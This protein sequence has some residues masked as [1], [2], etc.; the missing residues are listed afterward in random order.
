MGGHSGHSSEEH[1]GY[2]GKGVARY[3]YGYDV[4]GGYK[5][6]D[7]GHQESRNGDLTRGSYYTDLPDGR[8]IHVKYYV[9]GYSGFVA[10]VRYEGKAKYDSS[11]YHDDSHEAIN[12]Y[13]S[14]SGSD[15]R[16]FGGIVGSI[17]HEGSDEGSSSSSYTG[18]TGG[19]V[20]HDFSTS[21]SHEIPQVFSAA[22]PSGGFDYADAVHHEDSDEGAFRTPLTRGFNRGRGND[23]SD[24]GAFRTPP[25]GGFNRGRGNDD[26]DE[27]NFYTPPRGGF[28]RGRDNDDS[29]EGVTYNNL[30]F[31]NSGHDDSDERFPLTIPTAG[32]SFRG[33]GDG[34][35]SD[36]RFPLV[37]PN[38]GLG[39]RGSNQV[40][41]VGSGYRAPNNI[42]ST[43]AAPATGYGFGGSI[44]G[45][46]HDDSDEDVF[47][48]R[49]SV[50][51]SL[52]GY[53][54]DNSNEGL[55]FALSNINSLGHVNSNHL[56]GHHPQD[57]NEGF[58][59]SRSR[60][61]GLTG[62]SRTHL[63][64]RPNMPGY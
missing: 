50:G 21:D 43:Y 19:G 44:R 29:D 23:D 54:R 56:F 12:N 58:T 34:S 52:K 27:G 25:R 48:S 46:G 17:S 11:G 39:Y 30:N 22:G 60:G 51:N 49:N 63:G 18:Y 7:F 59:F 2:K 35:D 9:N 45:R 10:D 16:V 26:S 6:G 47:F 57:S 40:A 1:H 61:G 64:F 20:G 13:V 38:V 5:G 24:E 32:G 36:E 4:K 31:G 53:Y 41:N 14:S 37:R 15:E 33:R 42:G 8:R 62:Y 28:S 55:T 3:K